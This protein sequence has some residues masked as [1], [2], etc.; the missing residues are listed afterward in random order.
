MTRHCHRCGGEWNLAGQPGR[1]ES[2][3]RCA[4]DLRV[5]LN[6]SSYDARAAHQCRD[7]RADPVFEKA[8]GNFCEYFEFIRRSFA[9]PSDA[10]PRESAA[11][12]QLKKLLGD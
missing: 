7:R 9:P 1:S 11:R 3:H 2:C 8:S 4:A 5:C 6:C 10:H 12:D